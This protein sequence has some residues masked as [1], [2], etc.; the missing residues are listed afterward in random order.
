MKTDVKYTCNSCGKKYSIYSSWFSHKRAKHSEPRVTCTVCK[1]TFHSHSQMYK[2]AYTEHSRPAEVSAPVPIQTQV[3]ESEPKRRGLAS[4]VF[5][6]SFSWGLGSHTPTTSP[7]NG[8]YRE[9]VGQSWFVIN[10][11]IQNPAI[12]ALKPAWVK[13][14]KARLS[15]RRQHEFHWYL[16]SNSRWSS[17]TWI[18]CWTRVEFSF[19]SVNLFYK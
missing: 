10:I 5:Q 1:K 14:L 11:P 18:L 12:A 13:K 9:K 3:I 15:T 19:T 7:S 6:E 4:F 17:S 2:H 8:E 16:C